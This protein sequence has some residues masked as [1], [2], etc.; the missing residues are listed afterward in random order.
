MGVRGLGLRAMGW[1]LGY[2]ARP[3]V[4]VPTFSPG[5]L[6]AGFGVALLNPVENG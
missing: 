6:G 2:R 3:G 5:F 1:G 4:V